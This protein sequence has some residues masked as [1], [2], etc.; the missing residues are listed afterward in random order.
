MPITHHVRPDGILV[1]E[2]WGTLSISEEEI[3][4]QERLK[5]PL[6]FPGMRVLVNA[7]RVEPADSVNLIRHLAGIARA[8][9]AKLDCG[10][11]ALLVKSEVEYGMA[12]MYMTLTEVEHPNTQIFTDY[13]EALAWLKA[14]TPTTSKRS[15]SAEGS[16]SES[17]GV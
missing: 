1:L 9:A 4:L 2:R 13:E 17:P 3:N 5:D 10:A 8:T 11:V 15:E 16:S 14:Q 6:V 7:L 12:R